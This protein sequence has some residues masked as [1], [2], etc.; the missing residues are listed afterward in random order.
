MNWHPLWDADVASHS[1][2]SCATIPAPGLLLNLKEDMIITEEMRN[3]DT[4]VG[5]FLFATML[6][7]AVN[8]NILCL[9]LSNTTLFLCQNNR[10]ENYT[11]FLLQ[12]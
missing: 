1:F 9:W 11:Y 6:L 3:V 5:K 4:E 2:T 8:T 10:S 12:I 7:K